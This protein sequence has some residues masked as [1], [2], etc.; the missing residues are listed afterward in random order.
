MS[1]RAPKEAKPR[2]TLRHLHGHPN[3]LKELARSQA[4]TYREAY[5][6]FRVEFPDGDYEISNNTGAGYAQETMS[7]LE[8]AWARGDARRAEMVRLAPLAAWRDALYEIGQAISGLKDK[9]D[10]A[11]LLPA[12]RAYEAHCDE[13][14]AAISKELGV[15][16]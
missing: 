5:A 15:E 7:R 6:E 11:S 14:I 13:R 12:L 1:K 4:R 8:K 16:P 2:F 9:P 3:C 10:A